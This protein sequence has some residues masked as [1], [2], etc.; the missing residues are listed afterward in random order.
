MLAALVPVISIA[1][2]FVVLI[3][4]LVVVIV[5]VVLVEINAR[6]PESG[7]MSKSANANEAA[8]FDRFTAVPPD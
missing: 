5:P 3:V 7:A 4:P 1:V 6:C 2:A 8:L